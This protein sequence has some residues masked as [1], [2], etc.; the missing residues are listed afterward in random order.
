MSSHKE[1]IDKII[2]LEKENK[3][4]NHIITNLFNRGE[5]IAEKNSKDYIIWT[6]NYFTGM[7]YPIFKID[8]NKENNISKIETELNL[9]GKLWSVILALIILTF[10]SILIFIPIIEYIEFFCL[11]ETIILVVYFVFIYSLYWALKR[12]YLNEK[13]YLL[14]EL[15]VI[16]GQETQKS[17]EKKEEKKNEWSFKMTAFRIFAYPFSIFVIIFSIFYMLPNGNLKGL[18]GPPIV[19]MYLYSDLKILRNKRKRN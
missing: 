15:R 8:F 14:N 4:W 16:V 3:L 11:R 9:Y 19:G 13:K 1:K 5:T 2:T 10:S 7:F 17:I 6:S 18:L 12:V